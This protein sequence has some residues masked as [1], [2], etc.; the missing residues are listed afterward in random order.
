MGL[1][2]KVGPSASSVFSQFGSKAGLRFVTASKDGSALVAATKANK[3]EGG[4][5]ADLLSRLNKAKEEKVEAK[6]EVDKIE[7]EGE[8]KKGKRKAEDQD[9]VAEGDLSKAER[10]KRKKEKKAAL[11]AAE[12]VVEEA[13]QDLKEAAIIQESKPDVIIPPVARAAILS[14]NACVLSSLPNARLIFLQIS[15]QIPQSERNGFGC[16]SCWHSRCPG[17]VTAA[18]PCTCVSCNTVA[19]ARTNSSTR[20][21]RRA[22]CSCC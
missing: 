19:R 18:F 22:A 11:A 21:R 4:H 6:A 7:E 13:E 12:S 2:A 5:F 17:R 1:G 16:R 10:K 3:T 15:S 14:R 8:V 9:P 20:N